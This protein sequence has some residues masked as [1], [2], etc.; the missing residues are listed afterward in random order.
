[1]VTGWSAG[2]IAWPR[3]RALDTGGAGSGLLVE[4]ELARAICSES[5]TAL[6]YWWGVN[7]ETVWRWRRAFG[8]GRAGTEG[9]RRLIQVGAAKAA[10]SLRRHQW[11]DEERERRRQRVKALNLARNLKAGYHGPWWTEQELALLGKLPDEEVA[12]RTGRTPDAV[13][14]KRN[15]LG[16]RSASDRRRR[17]GSGKE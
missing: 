2:R 17:S 1:V 16:I 10:E 3:C 11:S 12:A 4:E 13:R 7:R 6:A 14:R 9:S 5:A 8:V 15:S